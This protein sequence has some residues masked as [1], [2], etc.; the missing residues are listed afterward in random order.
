MILGWGLNNSGQLG[1]GDYNNTHVP[2]EIREF[3][4]KDVVHMTGGSHHT[5]ALL[6]NGE[7][8]GFGRTDEGELGLG[9]DY[10]VEEEQEEEEPEAKVEEK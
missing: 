3:R 9:E 10:V 8:Y 4:D 1:I 6:A 2:I 5:I 7:V